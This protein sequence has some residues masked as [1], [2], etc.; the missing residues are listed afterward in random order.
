MYWLVHFN[1]KHVKFLTI[2]Q[3]YKH[4]YYLYT[5]YYP[6]SG[7]KSGALKSVGGVDK[8]RE[9]FRWAFTGDVNT[10][11]CTEW[12]KLYYSNFIILYSNRKK[13]TD[14]KFFTYNFLNDF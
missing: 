10:H 14:W 12:S 1:F 4:T 8:Y 6:L 5:L 11:T 7:Y 3:Y 9:L 13:Y 2:D